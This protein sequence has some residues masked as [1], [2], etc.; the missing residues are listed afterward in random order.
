MRDNS[1]KEVRRV[2]DTSKQH[3]RVLVSLGYDLEPAFMTAL[4]Q[5][6][7]DPATSFEW[8]K[9]SRKRA[10]KLLHYDEILHFL[11]IT[12]RASS[13]AVMTKKEVKKSTHPPRPVTSHA[14][15]ANN[16]AHC[17]LCPKEK[18][19]LYGCSKFKALSQEEKRSLLKRNQVCFNCLKSGH[20]RQCESSHRCKRC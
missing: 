4:I 17:I 16:S 2:H 3:I 5:T 11:E 6:K 18:H 14:A 19:P 12:A 13:E 8:K 20:Y 15:I 7:L 10:R 9:H 1:R